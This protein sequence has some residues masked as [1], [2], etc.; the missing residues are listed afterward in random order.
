[1]RQL[2]QRLKRYPLASRVIA[3]VLL[4]SSMV[5]LISMTVQLYYDYRIERQGLDGRI[6]AIVQTLEPG[7]SNS[8]WMIDDES[9]RIIMQGLLRLPEIYNVTLVTRSG[10]TFLAGSPPDGSPSIS[11][12]YTIHGGYPDRRPLAEMTLLVSLQPL[13]DLLLDRALVILAT[14]L[15]K[16]LVIVTFFLFIFWWLVSRHL[17]AL[18]NYAAGLLEEGQSGTLRLARRRVERDEL[19]RVVDA[20]N[21]LLT[22]IETQR[23]RISELEGE[24]EER[25][26]DA[27]DEA[28]RY[29]D[30]FCHCLQL[31][32]LQLE[33]VRVGVQ[34]VNAEQPDP[35]LEHSQV[36]L[37]RFGESARD[38]ERLMATMLRDAPA[39]FEEVELC[40]L[41]EQCARSAVSVDEASSERCQIRVIVGDGVPRFVIGD[42]QQVEDL[43]THIIEGLS[44]VSQPRQMVLLTQ[45]L[46]RPD[47]QFI[48]LR[49]NLEDDGRPLEES[50]VMAFQR[51]PERLP[52]PT[53][54]DRLAAALKFLLAQQ[55][56]FRHHGDFGLRSDPGRGNSLW[57]EMLVR[58]PVKRVGDA[59]PLN[60]AQFSVVAIG[61]P[62]SRVHLLDQV[63]KVAPDYLVSLDTCDSLAAFERDLGSD[64]APDLVLIDGVS[65]RDLV[66]GGECEALRRTLARVPTSL[67]VLQNPEDVNLEA[68]QASGV[69]ALVLED[70]LAAT[71]A[72]LGVGQGIDMASDSARLE[73]L[74]PGVRRLLAH[75]PPSSVCSVRVLVVDDDPDIREAVRLYLE[76]SGTEVDFAAHGLEALERLQERAYTL[77]LLDCWIAG[78]R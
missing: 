2:I 55:M 24:H 39:R 5:A 75:R 54:A 37:L 8:L 12:I 11:K 57:L 34:Q 56:V 70:E 46:E 31:L 21:V 52:E 73:F 51:M 65:G 10:K 20:F 18:S 72:R 66:V 1:M 6:D 48:R 30:F 69:S 61:F 4:F 32:Q 59:E 49:I 71:L 45:V 62:P 28:N 22:R 36:G 64:K 76:E 35:R 44:I 15:A 50:W 13:Y 9:S 41:L 17:E 67:V 26:Q 42:K 58:V 16:T 74:S 14:Q 7:L 38:L 40:S 63:F 53:T 33:S 19:S 29:Q 23:H 27:L 25:V 47:P 68:V 77:V 78:C 3:S 43:L 60:R